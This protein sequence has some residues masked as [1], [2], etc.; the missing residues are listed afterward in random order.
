MKY[1]GEKGLAGEARGLHQLSIWT[2]VDRRRHPTTTTA[3]LLVCR[4]SV[5]G[6]DNVWVRDKPLW[7]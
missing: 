6:A 3:K 4:F 1:P 2:G 7:L 5:F